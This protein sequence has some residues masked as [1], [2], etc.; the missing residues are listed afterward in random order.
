MR[1]RI[2]LGVGANRLGRADIQLEEIGPV[3]RVQG[4]QIKRPVPFGA[5]ESIPRAVV[6]AGAGIDPDLT[7]LPCPDGQGAPPSSIDRLGAL[8]K[9]RHLDLRDAPGSLVVCI[10]QC[11][12]GRS[13]RG[14][15]G[16]DV[17][18][19][20]E[21][22]ALRRPAFRSTTVDLEYKKRLQARE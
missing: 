19:R 6:A 18:T 22:Q 17:G 5:S 15:D 21:N 10:E 8:S 14:G 3:A 11:T 7:A 2:H 13:E 16:D 9:I 4:Q 1:M 12:D 20:I